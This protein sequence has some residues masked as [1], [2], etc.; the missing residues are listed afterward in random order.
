MNAA[1]AEAEVLREKTAEY[2]R[3][4]YSRED[5]FDAYCRK[6]GAKLFL[7]SASDLLDETPDGPRYMAAAPPLRDGTVAA[8]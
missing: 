3:A 7:Y 6:Y 2:L 1:K 4:L 8:A 5:V